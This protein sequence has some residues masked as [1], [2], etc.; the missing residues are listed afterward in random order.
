MEKLVGTYGKTFH[1]WHTDQHDTLPIGVPQI[2]MG[3]TA[4]GQ[5]DPALVE[6]RDQRFGIDSADKRRDRED[7]AAPPI[8]P[9][10]NSW[11]SGKVVQIADPTREK[12]DRSS[13]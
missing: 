10:A 8:A 11:E 13:H 12:S 1:T 4:D 2:M 9:G 7:I 5:L 6:A 3:F